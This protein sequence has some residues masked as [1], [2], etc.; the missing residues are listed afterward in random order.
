MALPYLEG[1]S[2]SFMQGYGGKVLIGCISWKENTR[3]SPF[4]E[5]EWG[6]SFKR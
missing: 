4:I 2:W 1:R 5:F 6:D 3:I